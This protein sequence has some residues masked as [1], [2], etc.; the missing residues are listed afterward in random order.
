MFIERWFANWLI[1]IPGD[2]FIWNKT[3]HGLSKYFLDIP[4]LDMLSLFQGIRQLPFARSDSAICILTEVFMADE[5]KMLFSLDGTRRNELFADDLFCLQHEFR[6]WGVALSQS[7]LIWEEEPNRVWLLADFQ[8]EKTYDLR[9]PNVIPPPLQVWSPSTEGEQLLTSTDTRAILSRLEESFR[10]T[11]EGG[12]DLLKRLPLEEYDLEG[13]KRTDLPSG[14][15]FERV[16]QD[17]LVVYEMLRGIPGFSREQL[18]SLPRQKIRTFVLR[19]REFFDWEQE[20]RQSQTRGR[21]AIAAHANLLQNIADF[22]NTVKAYL[23]PI[24][25][26]LNAQQ[27][28]ELENQV[29]ATVAETVQNLNAE[30]DRTRT[31]NAEAETKEA[32]RQKD[33]SD[34]KLEVQNQLAKKPISQYKQ[35]FANQAEKH[36]NTARN[37]LGV[38]GLLTLIFGLIFAWLLKELGPAG[39]ELPLVLQ[40]LLTKGFFLSLVYLL[41]NRCIKSYTAEKHLET[42]NRHRQNALETFDAFVAAAEGDRETRD[43]VLLAATNCIFD[44]NQ[45]GYLAAKTSRSESASPIQHVVKTIPFGKSPP[46]GE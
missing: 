24:I 27:V 18:L 38:T 9:L 35:I 29:N 28:A 43:A 32:E 37:W 30:V 13:L 19:L 6:E 31:I 11:H 23:G 36:Q 33:I 40:N 2:M 39:S 21:N 22:C 12:V 44:A 7:L 41:L 46:S 34:L 8:N 17:L 15:G 10:G 3:P 1:P 14:F 25:T 45:S 5:R 42:V 16:H 4:L 26:H 20:I